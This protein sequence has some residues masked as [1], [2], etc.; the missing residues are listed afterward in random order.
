MATKQVVRELLDKLPDDCSLA[1]VLYH[2]YVLER[3]AKGLD[4]ADHGRLIP[5][6]QVERELRRRWQVNGA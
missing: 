1:D 3:V 2:L 4:E 5:H 6:D